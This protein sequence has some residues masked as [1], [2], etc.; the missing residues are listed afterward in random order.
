[1]LF[2]SYEFIF[3]FIP[4]TL[5]G[6]FWILRSNHYNAAILWLVVTSLFFY[7]W[8]Q[9]VYLFLIG[10]SIVI[11]YFFG[12]NI[13]AEQNKKIRK[14][15]LVAGCAINLGLLGYFKYAGFIVA[16]LNAMSGSD[17]SIGNIVL[18]LAISFFTFQQIAYLVDAY[19]NETKEYNFL[20]YCLFVTF[21]PQLIAGPIVHHKE[22]MPQFHDKR[23][24]QFSHD[25]LSIGLT[26]FVI[27][28]FKKVVLADTAA[29]YATPVFKA[30]D[31]GEAVSFILAW[32]G[33][34]AYTFQLYFDFSG[35]S[36]MAIGLARMFGIRLPVNFF[37]PYK[38][39]N[40]IDFWRRWHMTLSR[41]LRDY[42]YIPLGGSRK[43]KSRRYLNLMMTMLLGGLWHGAAWTFVF[44]GFLHGFY[45][46]VN[47]AWRALKFRIGANRRNP[48]V[49]TIW[50][51]RLITFLCVV[52]GWVFFRA[53]TFDGAIIML[54]GMIGYNGFVL[55]QGL[56]ASN[57]ALFPVLTEWGIRFEEMGKISRAMNTL[58][59]CLLVIW[60][61][62][63][64]LQIMK[65]YRPALF[66]YEDNKEIG[67][68]RLWN[69]RPT[70]LWAL[71]ILSLS[72]IAIRKMDS[73]SEFLYY[74]F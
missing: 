45:L 11:N 72:I 33:S 71:I 23:L 53:E 57:S 22:M 59:L 31:G 25:N 47:H 56:I 36:D 74:N 54:Q 5:L 29:L 26:I 37:S 32:Q 61:A 50:S 69:W 19:Y 24:I 15:K 65:Y 30:V 28:L 4:V 70:K 64:T 3:L 55:P 51:S 20:Q 14:T 48:G 13:G 1:M 27:G 34:L 49:V 73:V 44:W 35:Y 12:M 58:V 9:P 46:I 68:R 41:F 8:W 67:R 62:P 38:A 21:F 42:V 52:V 17:I 60:G 10:F 6:F 18:P 7:G 16:N 66:V 43:G 40:I 63:N 2:N 39:T